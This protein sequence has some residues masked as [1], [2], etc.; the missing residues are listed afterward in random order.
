MNATGIS[1]ALIT[2]NEEQHIGECLASLTWCDEIIVVDSGSTDRT[3]DIAKQHGAHVIM[4]PFQGYSAQKNFAAEQAHNEWILSIDA[5]EVVPPELQQEIT[6]SL[7]DERNSHVV[8]YF[9][10]R[11]NLWLG[12]PIRHG[13]WYPDYTLRLYRRDCG[14][15]RGDSHELVE[16]DGAWTTL[17]HPLI[18]DTISDIHD[19]LRK[20]LLL[21]VLEVKE[22][23]ANGMR[24]YRLFPF[25]TMLLCAKDFWLGPKTGLGLR[26]IYKRRIKYK[27]ELM[28][29]L[30]LYPALRFFYMYVL[31]LGFLDGNRGFWL[32]YAS[33]A[34]EAMKAL[35]FWEHFVLQDR[36]YTPQQQATEDTSKL[37]MTVQ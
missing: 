5:D 15:W 16:V 18:H 29:L 25:H 10:P 7:A 22:A 19:H 6:A 28:W 12:K 24:L 8:G 30:P 31:K 36:K 27:L 35:R 3:V 2:L 13:G 21:G 32:A 9:V 14:K 4:Q 26:L 37:Y 11:L 17:R 20:A 34:V 1:A 33:G 23:R